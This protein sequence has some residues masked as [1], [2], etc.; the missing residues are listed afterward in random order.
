MAEQSLVSQQ[1]FEPSVSTKQINP[2]GSINASDIQSAYNRK[3]DV[4]NQLLSLSTT[5][6]QGVGSKL[7]YDRA[8][9]LAE[10]KV[11]K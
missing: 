5:F 1:G 11:D 2:Q 8:V 3:K 4:A 7:E 6:V 9:D 10:K